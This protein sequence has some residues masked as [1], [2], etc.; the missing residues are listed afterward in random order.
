MTLVL[1]LIGFLKKESMDQ[2]K[3]QKL[4]FYAYSWYLYMFNDIEEGL[5]N[6]LFKNDIEGWVHGPISRSLYGS[7]IFMVRERLSPSNFFKDIPDSDTEI[8]NFLSDIYNV[9]GSYTGNQ[10]ES[11]THNEIPWKESRKGLAPSEPGRKIIKDST[12]YAQ[13]ALLDNE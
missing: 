2:K 5:T 13:C 6:K 9:F 3:L 8:Q 7:Y 11:M 12:M 1:W 10:L 4:C